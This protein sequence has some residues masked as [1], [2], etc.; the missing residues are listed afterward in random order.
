MKQIPLVALS[1]NQPTYLKQLMLWWRW[2]HPNRE[3]HPI[4]IF[5]NGSSSP[6]LLPYISGQNKLL[7]ADI[8]A[9]YPENNFIANLNDFIDKHIKGAHDYYVLS[10]CDIMPHPATPPNY[11]EV[12]QQAIESGYHRAGFGLITNDL[13]EWLEKRANIQCNEIELLTNEV[14]INGVKGFQAPIDTTFCLYTTKNSGW[15][16]P[17]DGQDWS[18]CVRLFQAFHLGWYLHPEHINP[19]MDYYFTTAKQHEVGKP[20]AGANNNRPEK[21]TR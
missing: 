9:H 5:D 7:Y 20:S 13:P 8:V 16:A 2:Y 12:M 11:L 3:T 10:D 21:Y 4:Y 1:F 18:N 15:H 17:M 6:E 19:E 14:E